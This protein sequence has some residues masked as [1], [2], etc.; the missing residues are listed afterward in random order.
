MHLL[1]ALGLALIGLGSA[2]L[3]YLAA[4]WLLGLG[5][6]GPRPLLS[7][8]ATVLGVGTQLFSLGILAELVTAFNIQKSDTFSVLEV[9]EPGPPN[10]PPAPDPATSDRN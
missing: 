10:P 7:Y 2:G 4:I 3:A 8:S 1:G 9:T 5:P 6:I